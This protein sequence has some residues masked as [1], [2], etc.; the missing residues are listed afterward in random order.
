M[1]VESDA[2][3]DWCGDDAEDT[4]QAMVELDDGATVCPECLSDSGGF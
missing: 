3:C 1:S 4:G 2:I